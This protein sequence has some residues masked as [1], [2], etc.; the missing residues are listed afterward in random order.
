M[1]EKLVEIEV[2]GLARGQMMLSPAENSRNLACIVFPRGE[3]ISSDLHFTRTTGSHRE[4][5]VKERQPRHPQ[6]DFRNPGKR[7]NG[8]AV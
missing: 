5:D 1:K 2:K 6:E 8:E 7:W 3:G 4:I